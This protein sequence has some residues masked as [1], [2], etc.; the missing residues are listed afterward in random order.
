ME[1]DSYSTC[2]VVAALELK[3]KAELEIISKGCGLE[4]KK[5]K[6]HIDLPLPLKQILE[7]KQV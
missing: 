2:P 6:T 5:V 4:T 1:R 7:L 3:G